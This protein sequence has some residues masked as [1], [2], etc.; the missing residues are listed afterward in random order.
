MPTLKVFVICIIGLYLSNP[1]ATPLASHC[2]T[3]SLISLEGDL[4]L[5]K[6]LR[7]SKM[8]FPNPFI[9]LRTQSFALEIP[10]QRPLIRFLPTDVKAFGLNMLLSPF[11]TDFAALLA[12]DIPP[13]IALPK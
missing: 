5:K 10:A 13:L 7:P 4:I 6:L 3:S 8:P 2:P 9:L 1:T 12:A 11:I